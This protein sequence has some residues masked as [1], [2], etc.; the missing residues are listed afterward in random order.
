MCPSVTFRR[1]PAPAQQS[2]LEQARDAYTRRAWADAYAAFRAA[3]REAALEAPDVER[4]ARAAGLLARDE[5]FLNEL[6]RSYGLYLEAGETERAARA[7]FWLATRCLHLG[8]VSRSNAWFARVEKL[9]GEGASILGGYLLVPLAQRQLAAG[10]VELAVETA[11]RAAVLGASLRECDLEALAQSVLG[12]ALLRQG[13][14][15]RGLAALDSS[16][17]CAS[18][19]NVQPAVTG[20]VYCAAIASSSRVFALERAREWTAALERF[21]AAQ[22]QLVTFSGTC[23]VHCS[24]VHQISGEW[25]AA[26]REAERACERV[27]EDRTHHRGPLGNALYQ[28]AELKRVAGEFDAAEEL[29]RAASEN[30]REPQ[31]GLLLL[32]LAQ[33]K[34]DAALVAIRRVLA[35]VTSSEQRLPLLPAA[36][37]VTIENGEL[38]EARALVQE[39]E[40]A[41]E[42]RKLDVLSAM[43]LHARGSLALLENDPK[44]AL[45]PL[46]SA[47]EIWQRLGAPYLAARIR[48]ELARACRALDDCDGAELEL[49][50][51]ESTFEKLGARHDLARLNVGSPARPAGLSA[52]ELEVLRLVAS[53]LTN[54]AIAAELSLSE[55][56]VDRHVSNIFGK[57]NVSSRA[58]ATAYAYRNGLA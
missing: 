24:E 12:R 7:A 47:F 55:K 16:M 11:S 53:G 17:L 27:P 46:R 14:T 37:E 40:A 33:G 48:V 52:R 2:V 38:E 18:S 19:E 43:A 54:K 21:C 57:L 50:C 4:L 51:A 36:V 6:E 49:A 56:T 34:K 41:A 29:Y 10:E 5:E 30:G 58:A 32:R 44:G 31:P 1:V 26:A 39:L 13:E 15:E 25:S 9:A 22:P 23:L 28:Q 42:G 20:I 35:A 45:A 3:E 8:E